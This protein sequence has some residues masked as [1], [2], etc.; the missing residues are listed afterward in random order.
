MRQL[1][2]GL[3]LMA[4]SGAIADEKPNIEGLLESSLEA[5]DSHQ[6]LMSRVT[7][8]AGSSIPYHYHP[9]EEFLYVVSGSVTLKIQGQPDRQLQAGTAQK[10][11]AK[12]IHSAA[13]NELESEI[14]VFRVHPSGMPVVM[15]PEG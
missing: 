8:P 5:I 6:V 3:A 14:I 4:S 12:A 15:K 10:I 11:P 2:M 9:S 7:V 1:W 13:T